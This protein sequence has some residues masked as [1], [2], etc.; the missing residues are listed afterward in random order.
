MAEVSLARSGQDS[1]TR[2]ESGR[3]LFAER[4]LEFRHGGGLRGRHSR[5]SVCSDAPVHDRRARRGSCSARAPRSTRRAAAIGI[6]TG[7]VA[8]GP[9]LIAGLL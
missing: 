3:E 6:A 7:I 2:V 8:G 5:N 1:T 4:G 9:Y